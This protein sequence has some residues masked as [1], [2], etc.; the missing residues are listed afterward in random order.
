MAN[1]LTYSEKLRDPRWQQKRLRIFERDGWS[2]QRCHSTANTLHVHHRR[3]LPDAE[4]WDY[5]EKLLV[6]LCEF[7]HQQETDE[8]RQAIYDL[9][10]AIQDAWLATD[11]FIFV[12]ALCSENQEP[13]VDSS[14]IHPL[15]VTTLTN[16][17]VRRGAL[18]AYIEA[19]N[20]EE[21]FLSRLRAQIAVDSKFIDESHSAR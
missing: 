13:T 1:E 12:A 7:C 3:Y 11:V 4:P 17:R 5:P 15:L 10:T 16:P 20:P 8:M 6:T 19:F 21:P 9:Q 2:C 18:Q 14:L